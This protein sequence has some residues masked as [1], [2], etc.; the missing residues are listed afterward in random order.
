MSP[1]N[2]S[3]SGVDRPSS[4]PFWQGFCLPGKLL[5]LLRKN[6]LLLG[7]L[8]LLLRESRLLLGTRRFHI[9]LPRF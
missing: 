8:L 2:S 7:K 9:V 6:F 1:C 3:I 5:L 4:S